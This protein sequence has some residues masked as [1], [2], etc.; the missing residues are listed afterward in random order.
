MTIS[1]TVPYILIQSQNKK[2]RVCCGCRD[3]LCSSRVIFVLC[4]GTALFAAQPIRPL[5]FGDTASVNRPEHD[6]VNLLRIY[7]RPTVCRPVECSPSLC[8]EV[9]LVPRLDAVVAAQSNSVCKSCDIFVLPLAAIERC[10]VI[11]F[12]LPSFLYPSWIVRRRHRTKPMLHRWVV[13]C[14]AVGRR[15]KEDVRNKS[16]N[17]YEITRFHSLTRSCHLQS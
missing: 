15:N 8:A 14:I 9:S 13:R 1:T 10:P 16:W 17:G 3:Q 2:W 6:F 4:T 11:D 5:N 7:W 12:V